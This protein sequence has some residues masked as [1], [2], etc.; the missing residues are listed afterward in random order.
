MVVGHRTWSD[1]TPGSYSPTCLVVP[2]ADRDSLVSDGAPRE[3]APASRSGANRASRHPGSGE[4]GCGYVWRRKRTCVR[5]DR[6]CCFGRRV[7]D[8]RPSICHAQPL[9]LAWPRTCSPHRAYPQFGLL[10]CHPGA[11]GSVGRPWW[12]CVRRPAGGH[13]RPAQLCLRLV[14]LRAGRIGALELVWAGC[15]QTFVLVGTGCAALI[16]NRFFM[17]DFCV[18]RG[19]NQRI[20]ARAP[21]PRHRW[22]GSCS[23]VS[24]WG[25][26]ALHPISGR[27]RVGWSS[28][29]HLR[30]ARVVGG[31][32]DAAGAGQP[33]LVGGAG[34]TLAVHLPPVPGARIRIATAALPPTSFYVW[35]PRHEG[36]VPGRRPGVGLLTTVLSAR[37]RWQ[38]GWEDEMSNCDF[39]WMWPR[40]RTNR[41]TAIGLAGA[42]AGPGQ[43]TVTR[44]SVMCDSPG[45]AQPRR[46][47]LPCHKGFEGMRPFPLVGD[48]PPR[49]GPWP[50]LS[51]AATRGAARPAG[52]GALRGLTGP[53]FSAASTPSRITAFQP[54]YAPGPDGSGS[55][56]PRRMAQEGTVIPPQF[57]SLGRAGRPGVRVWPLIH[58]GDGLALRTVNRRVPGW[59]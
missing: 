41:R 44:L 34:R 37:F 16:R 43:R 32:W 28:V 50:G 13:G 12:M 9:R 58:W 36:T 22:S 2:V 47:R 15:Q 59:R 6:G 53:E 17:V 3:A 30:P 45:S 33:W 49:N 19:R 20:P 1:L 48:H 26:S 54:W 51:S 42:R 14:L 55:L 40:T 21:M 46:C 27:P 23:M 31:Q 7:G 5:A 24:S 57:D 39:S 38:A 8:G 18:G 25:F 29:Q 52:S 56:D 10:E 4:V 35:C 11:G